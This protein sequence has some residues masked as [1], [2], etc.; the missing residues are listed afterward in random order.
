MGGA[1]SDFQPVAS[2]SAANAAKPKSLLG[3]CVDKASSLLRHLSRA[4]SI[5]GSGRWREGGEDRKGGQIEREGR[6]SSS[7]EDRS[8]LARFHVSQALRRTN[9]LGGTVSFEQCPQATRAD[10]RGS[11]AVSPPLARRV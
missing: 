2:A 3:A 8:I 7:I 4:R 6:E 10:R 11:E 5:G 1:G 9:G